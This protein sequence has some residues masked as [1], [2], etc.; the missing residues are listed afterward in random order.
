MGAV[1][2]PFKGSSNNIGVSDHTMFWHHLAPARKVIEAV[3][4]LDL[5]IAETSDEHNGNIWFWKLPFPE[6]LATLNRIR[7]QAVEDEVGYQLTSLSSVLYSL[8]QQR[9]ANELNNIPFNEEEDL[10]LA[11]E[12]YDR[13]MLLDSVVPTVQQALNE[14]FGNPSEW[15]ALGL[16]AAN[17][18]WEENPMSLEPK[19]IYHS[20]AEADPSSNIDR[21]EYDED[22][23]ILMVAFNSGSMYRYFDVKPDVAYALRSSK[24]KGNSFD[25]LIKRGGYRFERIG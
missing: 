12:R 21:I 13:Y 15:Q 20:A 4:P 6:D 17:N 8:K 25:L 5:E 11:Q 14:R 24:S 1:I 7:T 19:L 18:R 2:N 10:L 23:A 3:E 9:E 22:N 16:E